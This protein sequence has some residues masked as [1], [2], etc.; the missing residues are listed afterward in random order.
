MTTEGRVQQVVE[1]EATTVCATPTYALRMAQVA[2]EMGLDL[3]ASAVDKLILSGEPA[4]SI[5]S[6][7]RLIESQWGARA[8]DTAGMT[9][10]GTIMMF[11]CAEQ[12]GG[13][14]IIEDN[15]IEVLNS[16]FHWFNYKSVPTEREEQ[17]I[18]SESSGAW[19]QAMILNVDDFAGTIK[20]Q[21]SNFT[22]NNYLFKTCDLYEDE[23]FNHETLSASV[24]Q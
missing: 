10:I 8:A 16:E 7:K 17:T 2:R 4:G 13:A 14:H 21:A 18:V 15:F 20:I 11:E 5:A 23:R 3:E 6:T 1:M 12:P 24:R 9:E 22:D 19:K